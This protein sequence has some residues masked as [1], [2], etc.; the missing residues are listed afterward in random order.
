MSKGFLLETVEDLWLMFIK[1]LILY[2]F[3]NPI[4]AQNA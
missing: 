4:E 1:V 3:E 2:F